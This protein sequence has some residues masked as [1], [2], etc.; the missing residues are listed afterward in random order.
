MDLVSIEPLGTSVSIHDD[1]SGLG[2]YIA[3]EG[4]RI[5]KFG[6]N[7]VIRTDLNILS[8]Q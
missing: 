3:A 8:Y 2:N 7:K 6:L 1:G 5:T 4:Q